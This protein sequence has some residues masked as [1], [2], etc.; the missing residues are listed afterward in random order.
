MDGAFLIIGGLLVLVLLVAPVLAI[1]AFVR[2]RRLADRLNQVDRELQALWRRTTASPDSTAAAPT[3]PSMAVAPPAPASQR[4]P[5]M[6][7]ARPVAPPAAASISAEAPEREVAPAAP[8]PAEKPEPLPRPAALLL[9]Q[10]ETAEKLNLEEMLGTN[11]LAKIGIAILVLGV[12]FFLAWQLR[13]LGP[14]GKVT[15]GWTIGL[16]MLG[17][18]IYFEGHERYKMLA[19]AAVGGGWALLFFV[20]YAMYHIDATRVLSTPL[21]SLVV[22]LTVAGT[23]VTH[24]LRYRSQ[25]V[26]GVAFLLAF[27]TTA[28]NRADVYSLAAGAVLAAALVPI[29]LRMGWYE[30]EVFGILAVYLNH[31]YWLRPIIEPMGEHHVRFPAFYASAALLVAYWAI[32]RASYLLRG[33]VAETRIST[34]AAVLTTVMMLSVIKYQAVDP[35][36][37]FPFLLALGAVEFVLGQ[38]ARRRAQRMP[39]VLLSTLGSAFLLAAI[40]FRVPHF[41]PF[42]VS[43]V[44]LVEAQAL[45]V[46]G[47]L[48]REIV[49]TR[50]GM[51]AGAAT[52]LQMLSVPAARVVGAR[53]DD[54]S[55]VLE[56]SLGLLFAAA[57][58]AF[59]FNAHVATRR[60]AGLFSEEGD[61]RAARQTSY[62]G[63]VMLL[64]GAYVAFPSGWTAVAWM[65]LSLALARSALR[66]ELPGLTLQANAF[67]ALAFLRILLINL[68]STDTLP[69]GPVGLHA[70]VLTISLV[71]VMLYFGSR[72][73]RASA[74]EFTR[75]IPDALTWAASA[76][77]TLLAWYELRTASVALGWTLFGIILYEL[78]LRRES[79]HLRL[80]AYTALTFA[81][82]RV[83]YVNLN[84]GDAP[85]WLGPRVYTT[86]PIAAA[87]FY[88][89]QRIAAQEDEAPGADRRR[90]ASDLAAWMG[91]LVLAAVVRF[92]F[93]L[94][95]VGAA[96]AGL[97]LGTAALG[98]YAG[99]R[100]FLHQAMFLAL[101]ACFRSAMHN[102]YERS[103]FPA[104]GA[105]KPSLCIFVTVG[106]LLLSLAFAFR[107]RVSE[108]AA[109]GKI[110][111]FFRTLDR[112]PELAL[113][114]L[115]TLLLTFYL[116][117]E[118][119]GGSIT[120]AWG[121]QAVAVFI[122][123]LWVKQRSFRLA[124]LAL[125]L[126]C[127][128]K[129]AVV[130]FWRLGLRDRA[131]TF[132]VL[133]IATV[134]ISVL[135]SRQRDLF[136]KIL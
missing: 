8:L 37:A 129:I 113:F 81:F 13:E 133:G 114:F 107:M 74:W 132:I 31:Y 33:E 83:F 3:V 25:A 122:F 76:C 84:A 106:L 35:R 48:T 126:L 67:A 63:A 27:G 7:E 111:R 6:P 92:E 110:A 117:V 88:L 72:W 103:Y 59:Y 87:L 127:I 10:E 55:I 120:I 79:L 123:A 135:Y 16:G 116:A 66:W 57:A 101:A 104:P 118:Y 98:W 75:F 65:A 58:G 128:G 100:V 93:Q 69:V 46:A 5:A 2:T 15:V 19:R 82:L 56:L 38:I 91:M 43:V 78:G 20:S 9:H 77:V 85:S 53:M 11:W 28:L 96:W 50:L 97:A 115:P 95:W 51:A 14:A 68:Q 71:A 80:Q 86:V 108:P 45:F 125:L 119:E 52:L 124:G 22:M 21:Q 102:L 131:L 32:F 130:D 4:P 39:F 62:A 90:W 26:T 12:T 136:K 70:R 30:L 17:A 49:F 112:R 24:T 34:L 61:K 1:I 29:V 134:L 121:L 40:P 60:W 73:G 89:H 47:V 41:T 94:D 36:M 109:G 18:G 44:W 42:L 23:M 99:R 64:A 54:G 105:Y